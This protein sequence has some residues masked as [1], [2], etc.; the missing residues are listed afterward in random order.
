MT[1]SVAPRALQ[2][3]PSPIRKL[4]PLAEEA[5]SRGV[6]VYHLNIGQPD[7]E[8]PAPFLDVVRGFD[9]PN[10]AYSPSQGEKIYIE[11]LL[12]YYRRLGHELQPEQVQVTIGGSEAVLFTFLAIGSPGDQVLV[13]EPFYTNYLTLSMMAGLEVVPITTRAADNF[14]LPPAAELEKRLTPRT[15]AILVCNPSNPT[16]TILSPSEMQ[17]LAE[18]V[19][20]HDL[21]LIC[22]EVYREFVY[23]GASVQSALSLAGLEDRVIVVDSISKRYSACGARIGCL[24]SRNPQVMDCALRLAQAR[25]SA[26]TLGQLGAAAMKD[27]GLHYFQTT[28]E[29]YRKRRNIVHE[30][31]SSIPGV[32]THLPAGAFYTMAKLPVA[33][34]EDFA[35]WLLTDFSCNGHTVMF[36]PAAGFYATPGLGTD[37]IRIAYV[38]KEADLRGAMT[39][40]R[41]GLEQYRAR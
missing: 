25:L 9:R 31:L 29:E 24:V 22:D 5:R 21:F 41:R 13:P 40:L 36:A 6:H 19:R 16:G 28:V 27:M 14:C 32:L 30:E 35:R 20:K 18:L 37:E 8:T 34:A 7:L 4:W 10:V 38:L 17:S 2:F 15:R 33:D 3:P 11:A 23:D 39:C 1:P 26:P 12:D